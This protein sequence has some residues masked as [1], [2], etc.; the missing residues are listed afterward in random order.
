V[1][2]R[3]HDFELRSPRISRL[4]EQ[5]GKAQRQVTGAERDE[6]TDAGA[7][8]GAIIAFVQGFPP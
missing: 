6:T 4:R 3:G 5:S 8:P 7:V 2:E 1:A